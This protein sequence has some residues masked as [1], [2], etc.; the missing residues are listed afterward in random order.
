MRDNPNQ[1]S[2]DFTSRFEK[3]SFKDDVDISGYREA[4]DY[5]FSNPDIKNI[6]ISGPYGSG[7][8][9]ILA[10]YEKEKRD[11][12]I[13][14]ISLA[15]FGSS[16]S[17]TDEEK[18]ALEASLEGKIL[19]QLIHQVEKSKVPQTN[20]R[21]KAPLSPWEILLRTLIAVLFLMSITHLVFSYVWIAFVGTFEDCGF[22]KLLELT[23]TPGSFFASGCI[24][25]AIITHYI[26]S[27]VTTQ[28]YHYAVRKLSLQGNDIE[29]FEDENCSYFDKYLNEVIYLV[30][31]SG[32]EVI[33]FEDIDRYNIETIFSRLRE[34]NTLANLKLKDKKKVIRFVFLLKD[35]LFDSKD[36]T[37]FFDYI[38]PVVPVV[39]SSNSYDQLRIQLEK[40]GTLNAFNKYFLEG[41][42]IYIDDM[43]LLIN[44]CNE[45]H[46]YHHRLNVQNNQLTPEKLL[47]LITYK[48]LFPKDFTLLQSN[49]GYIHAIFV[50]KEELISNSKKEI[51]A[52]IAKKKEQ[53]EKTRNEILTQKR[54]L[55]YSYAVK[56][57]SGFNYISNIREATDADL[58]RI[59]RSNLPETELPEYIRRLSIADSSIE[60]TIKD[61]LEECNDLEYQI[62]VLQGRHLCE[63]I[64]HSEGKE[65]LKNISIVENGKDSGF[66]EI[67]NSC[68]FDLLAYLILNGYIDESYPDYL[69]YFYPNSLSRKDKIF[70]RRVLDRQESE[71]SYELDDPARVLE[72]IRVEDFDFPEVLNFSLLDHLLR[73]N[74]DSEYLKHLI[75]H[76]RRT[77]NYRFVSQYLKVTADN[78]AFVFAINSLWNTFIHEVIKGEH[79]EAPQI[80][81]F[82]VDTLQNSDAAL[83]SAVNFEGTLCEY[84]STS[85]DYLCIEKPD[86]H[87]IISAFILLEVKFRSIDFSVSHS[88]L[89]TKVY[90]HSLYQINMDNINLML[91]TMHNIT[92]AK[93]LTEQNYTII[94]KV[95]SEPLYSYI[96]QNICSYLEAWLSV[97]DVIHDEE[98]CVISLLNNQEVPYETKEEYIR[99]ISG[100][101]TSLKSITD[102]KTWTFLMLRKK[103]ICSEENLWTF[104]KSI[105]KMDELTINYINAFK[106]PINMG[107]LQGAD[108]KDDRK[109]FFE[110]IV[111]SKTI[112]NNQYRDL[113]STIKVDWN[114]NFSI[115]N[116]EHQKVS[117][118]INNHIISMGLSMLQFMRSN[119]PSLLSEYIYTNIDAYAS[120]MNASQLVHSELI[121]VLDM[122]VSDEIK[123]KLI[124]FASHPVS[125]INTRYSDDLKAHVLQTKPDANDFTSLYLEYGTLSDQLKIITFK[126]ALGAINS[127]LNGT[128]M[129]SYDLYVDLITSTGLSTFNKQK[130]LLISLRNP[131]SGK[132]VKDYLVA[133]G[134]DEF[135][136]IFSGRL[137]HSV[138]KDPQNKEILE[139]LKTSHHIKSYNIN[140]DSTAYIVERMSTTE[141]RELVVSK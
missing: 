25:L 3:L 62:H 47:A 52:E 19:N 26:K 82:T 41:L 87:K 100:N 64:P 101:I 117:I 113:V 15:H 7:K 133:A 81:K 98:K 24:G 110:Q 102:S 11:K 104:W 123:K 119:Y 75:L 99:K 46:I 111:S 42:A 141:K 49:L 136:K 139:V 43:R 78:D 55:M 10:T 70:V 83:L 97:A 120:I 36:R 34:V 135:A 9:S 134:K 32:V 37:K 121:M 58:D 131:A 13:I 127:I 48:N 128:A 118:L 107:I 115:T 91:T 88:F 93:K 130:L 27:A 94:S 74:K 65:T 124:G 6:A 90:E 2:K 22:R 125:I 38:I 57:K 45:Y 17:T 66:E 89:F 67:K 44:I 103:I 4:L 72:K 35:D 140:D 114:Y 1:V 112:H 109:T 105:R 63:L 28:R 132:N 86:T 138:P 56:C 23:T 126:K 79:M 69:S 92:D 5:A 50:S 16:G 71:Y 20:F 14:H 40:S 29:L 85:P 73:Y 108:I 12:R 76:L 59:I 95:S 33:V 54:D 8:S 106:S 122:D 31:E 137:K 129:I 30:K 51:N 84:I 18:A 80:R 68:Y 96:H 53:L 61:I 60:Q 39:G 21:I 77:H 116:F